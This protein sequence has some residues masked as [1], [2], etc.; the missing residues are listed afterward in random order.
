MT[1]SGAES[2]LLAWLVILALTACVVAIASGMAA[3]FAYTGFDSALWSIGMAL[4]NFRAV[5]G[6]FAF[7]WVFL[8]GVAVI[9]FYLFSSFGPPSPPIRRRIVW[10]VTLWA[11]AGMGILVTL[12]AGRF[13]GRE[14]LGYHPV[15]SALILAGWLLFAWNYF[16]QVGI[17]LKSRPVYVYMWS[18]G[19]I[20]FVIA[21]IESHL[22]LIDSLSA[23]PVRDIAIQWK[24]NG[25]LVGAFNLLVYGSLIYVAGRLRGDDEY[26]YSRTAFALFCVGTLNTFTNYGH[27]TYHLPQTALIHWISFFVS[28]LEMFILA[29]CF[30][31]ILAA[32][33]T[34]RA[35]AELQVPDGFVRSATLWTFLMLALAL[36]ISVPPLNAL[37]HGTHVVV[38]HSMGSMIGIDS[39]ILWAALSYILWHLLGPNHLVVRGA[40]ARWA[41]PLVNIFLF[42][43]L[44]AFLARGVAAGWTRYV[45]PSA[46]DFSVLVQVF[47]I[48]MVVSGLGLGATLLWML[49]HWLTAL[50]SIAVTTRTLVPQEIR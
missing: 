50:R 29:K 28:M 14:Y 26:A 19:I 42:V 40:R 25:T 34:P 18:V 6:A 20:L 4:Q 7:G 37:I 16:A 12:L 22:Y 11:T 32:R 2:R 1:N 48:V 10:H 38:A 15:F 47:P 23:R 41:V 24:S 44:A 5:H 43:F 39:M 45:G 35:T 13:T 8:G 33:K 27:H 36:S 17:R 30:L 21:Y 46:P 9:Y 31:D 3:A 49:G